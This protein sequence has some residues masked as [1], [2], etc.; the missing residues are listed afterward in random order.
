MALLDHFH[1]PL[2]LEPS[3]H[4]IHN[5]WSYNL[6]ADLNHRL[7][8]HCFARSNVQFGIEID[9][10]AYTEAQ[11]AGQ[12]REIVTAPYLAQLNADDSGAAL[13]TAWLPSLPA[14]TIPFEVAPENVE[15][16]I[17]NNFANP[18]LIGAIELVSPANKDRAAQRLAFVAKCESYLRQGMGLVVVDVVTNRKANL[19]NDLLTRLSAEQSQQSAAELYTTAYHPVGREGQ[20]SLEIWHEELAIGQPLPNLP[21]WLRGEGCLPV[22]LQPTYQKT[23]ADLRITSKSHA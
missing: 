14:F 5:G 6:A 11:Q 23:C 15:V 22:L 7:P 10:A 21:L 3:W 9:I 8:E 16:L 1:P 12:L 17:F 2:S 13:E 19:H 20:A 4:S 18:T